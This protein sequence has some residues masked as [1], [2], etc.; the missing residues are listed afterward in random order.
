MSRTTYHTHTYKIIITFD[1]YIDIKI[2]DK[3]NDVNYS[4]FIDDNF[5]VYHKKDFIAKIILEYKDITTFYDTIR[6]CLSKEQN[7]NFNMFY[8]EIDDN[9]ELHLDIKQDDFLTTFLTNYIVI[10]CFLDPVI[11]EFASHYRIN[12]DTLT[13]E[14]VEL[15][16]MVE[17][18]NENY[19]ILKNEIQELKNIIQE[20]NKFIEIQKKITRARL[21][22]D[23]N[24]YN[25]FDI[26]TNE[27][28]I[29]KNIDYGS[30]YMY[31][32]NNIKFCSTH[33]YYNFNIDNSVFKLN[34]IKMSFID[35]VM[36]IPDDE[37]IFD[38][39]STNK[40]I[41]ENMEY[42]EHIVFK[43]TFYP[44]KFT[45][46]INLKKITIDNVTI[47]VTKFNTFINQFTGILNIEFINCPII[48]D[49]FDLKMRCVNHN[50]I[51]TNSDIF[52]QK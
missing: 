44:Y 21:D 5:N 24:E 9:L 52:L 43:N 17:K 48:G 12:I 26:C 37:I 42:L 14:I 6:K 16:D 11:D 13:N 20:Q 27:I 22:N 32:I 3:L 35:N 38:F 29:V 34:I 1:N 50:I 2:T 25:S 46:C 4:C 45:N 7:Y 31:K 49:I 30:N 36:D 39:S 28:S 8:N 19:E 40:N 10:Q 18:Q 47:N 33:Y 23:L 15:K 41:F 51:L